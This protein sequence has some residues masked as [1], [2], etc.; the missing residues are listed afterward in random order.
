M[1]WPPAP[2]SPPAL[3]PVRRRNPQ[4]WAWGPS[5]NRSAEQ[6]ERAERNCWYLPGV[7]NVINKLDA[8]P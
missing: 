7:R 4:G 5:V 1:L 8:A 3:D 2:A 6:K